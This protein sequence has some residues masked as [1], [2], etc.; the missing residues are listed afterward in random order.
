MKYIKTYEI[1]NLPGWVDLQKELEGFYKNFEVHCK[2]ANGKYLKESEYRAR[3]Y[4][5]PEFFYDEFVLLDFLYGEHTGGWKFNK[6]KE[7]RDYIKKNVKKSTIESIIKKFENDPTSYT[8]LVIGLSKRPN[9]RSPG[10]F[11]YIRDA[12]VQYIYFLFHAAIKKAP[13]YIKNAN[14]YNL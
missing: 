11:D 4:N 6:L 10:S 8:D 7:V 5:I 2:M 9:F 1:K 14:K 13:E 12:A 3:T